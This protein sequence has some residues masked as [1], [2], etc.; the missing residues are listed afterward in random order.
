MEKIR[1]HKATILSSFWAFKSRPWPCESS[2]ILV[3]ARM[4]VDALCTRESDLPPMYVLIPSL[5]SS[6]I[7]ADCGWAGLVKVLIE[8]G[9]NLNHCTPPDD[10]DDDMISGTSVWRAVVG[11]HV[12]VVKLLVAA[13]ADVNKF[14]PPQESSSPLSIYEV[15]SRM[16]EAYNRLRMYS[17]RASDPSCPQ[18]SDR[19][20]QEADEMRNEIVQVLVNPGAVLA[21]DDKE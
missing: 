17:N 6:H 8:A 15:E 1:S 16:I 10:E 21:K 5:C 18:G 9:A 14:G 2:R 11:D 19:K 20:L 12:E 7:A 13:G 3:S 4:K